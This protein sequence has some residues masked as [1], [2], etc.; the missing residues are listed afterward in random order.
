MDGEEEEKKIDYAE[1]LEKT[2]DMSLEELKRATA[3][4]E[5]E[6]AGIDIS[7]ISSLIKLFKS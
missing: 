2:E 7:D 3:L 5:M 4:K 1:L 6:E